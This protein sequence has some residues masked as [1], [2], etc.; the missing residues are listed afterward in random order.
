MAI[1]LNPGAMLKNVNK[2]EG[3]TWHA[4]IFWTNL[5]LRLT[6]YTP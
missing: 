1:Y 4:P 2:K 6:D 5:M 3:K